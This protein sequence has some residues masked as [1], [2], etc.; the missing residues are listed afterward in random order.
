MGSCG[1]CVLPALKSCDRLIRAFPYVATAAV[2]RTGVDQAGQFRHDNH[3]R[4]PIYYVQDDGWS[5]SWNASWTPRAY[6]LRPDG[7][8]LWRQDTL[9]FEERDARAAISTF[10]S[11]GPLR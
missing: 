11:G 7:T 4:V 6:L 10:A 5:R 3:L 8:L 2:T 9:P 1:R